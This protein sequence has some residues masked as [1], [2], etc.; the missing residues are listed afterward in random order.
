M[1]M[2]GWMDGCGDRIR[3]ARLCVRKALLLDRHELDVIT[4]EAGNNKYTIAAMLCCSAL[5]LCSA[6]IVWYCA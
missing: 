2:D 1:F 5:L 6:A 4:G 3:L